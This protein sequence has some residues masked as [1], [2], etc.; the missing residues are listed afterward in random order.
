MFES[1]KPT[2]RFGAFLAILFL[3]FETAARQVRS[4]HR[5]AIMSIVLQMMQTMVMLLAFIVFFSMLGLRTAPIRGTFLLFMMSGIFM[6]MTHIRA[7]GAVSGAAGPTSPMMQHAPMNAMI[8]ICGAALSALYTQFLIAVVMLFFYHTMYEPLYIYN[9]L[10]TLGCFLLAWGS[11]CCIGM[12]F[13]AIRPWWPS[14]GS[15][16][17]LVYQRANMVASGKMLAANTLSASMIT[18]FS[19][20]PL[21]HIIDQVRGH[22][23]INYEPM[24]TNIMYPIYISII[25]LVIGFVFS[26]IKIG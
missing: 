15:I 22:I 18:M 1:R 8:A 19:W 7:V 24:R 26:Y 6:F 11:G 21:F 16:L 9:P 25:F 20:N 3:T 2:T 23:F 17:T 5:N 10:G 12:V 14:M 4:G 13:R